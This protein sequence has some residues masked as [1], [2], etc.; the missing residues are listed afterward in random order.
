MDGPVEASRPQQVPQQHCQISRE[1]AGL[2]TCYWG[3]EREGEAGTR[4]PELPPVLFLKQFA[5]EEILIWCQEEAT[6]CKNL[7]RLPSSSISWWAGE[8]V[9]GSSL[10]LHPNTAHVERQGASSL[11]ALSLCLT[12][13]D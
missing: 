11:G 7:R 6:F 8:G 10:E 5:S 12:I 13:L 2:R 1:Y 4:E 3:E 9:R